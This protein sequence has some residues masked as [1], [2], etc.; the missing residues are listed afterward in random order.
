MPS[1]PDLPTAADLTAVLRHHWMLILL[2]FAATLSGVY[3]TLWLL[4]EQYEAEAR[5]LVKLGRENTEVPITV[6]K[7][8]VYVTG[9]QK[10]EINS[11]IQL[12]SSRGL[13]ERTVDT[14]GVERFA[15]RPTP[16]ET[17]FQAVK[18]YLK[19]IVRG[20]K[21]LLQNCL[22]ILDLK[23]ALTDREKAIKLVTEA[24]DAVRERDSNVIRLALRLPDPALARETVATMLDFYQ[25]RHVDVRRDANIREVFE[26]QATQYD[27]QLEDLQKAILEIKNHWNLTSVPEQ[28]VKLL[29]RLNDLRRA[30]DKEQ[31]QFAMLQR[32]KATL[33][34]RLA[35]LPRPGDDSG[36]ADAEPSAPGR[37]AGYLTPSLAEEFEAERER[38]GVTLA[39][40][41]A[42]LATHQ[43][44]VAAVEEE[45]ARL[46]VG[47]DELYVAELQRDVVEEKY[48]TYAKRREEARIAEELDVRRVANVVILS[49]PT[50]GAEPV[51]PRKMLIMGVGTVAAL[52]IAIGVALLVDW[53]TGTIY[54]PRELARIDGSPPLLGTI[55][56][57]PLVEPAV[58]AHQEEAHQEEAHQKDAG[59]TLGGGAGL[60]LSLLLG[61][62]LVLWRGS[63]TPWLGSRSPE[64]VRRLQPAR[65][66][67]VLALRPGEPASGSE[68]ADAANG[69]KPPLQATRVNTAI[70]ATETPMQVQDPVVLG[71][72]AAGSHAPASGTT[73]AAD[74]PRVPQASAAVVSTA[75][76]S[77][78]DS[79]TPGYSIQLAALRSAQAA[80]TLRERIATERAGVLEGLN[81]HV[82]PGDP[83]PGGGTL[84]RVRIGPLPSRAAARN[85]CAALALQPE[86]CWIVRSLQEPH[87]D[88]PVSTAATG[89][90]VDD[91]L[92]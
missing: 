89:R 8:G 66:A 29:E 38:I 19:Q 39:G 33:D 26:V 49:P 63:I 84:Y 85:L 67:P 36:A 87:P 91:P 13:I 1:G 62:T 46:N 42:S 16:P 23:K 4:A 34:D 41:N 11:Y 43:R 80:E 22:I 45:L 3:L 78:R 61:I 9:V 47:E 74:E 69:A 28:R 55:R 64:E 70:A 81:P 27:R 92:H 25:Q 21:G 7:G 86:G 59:R 90:H 12:L 75:T 82:V 15:F 2:V 6:E 44:H 79:L 71:E 37:G 35:R 32:R 24:T 65:L 83:E 18:Y 17:F 68:P 76:S 20:V 73:A 51:Y 88:M 5:L 40:L 56:V 58:E 31:G 48:V 52:I 77:R 30:I 50:V 57:D 10:E 54:G 72:P 53:Y 14:L 60:A